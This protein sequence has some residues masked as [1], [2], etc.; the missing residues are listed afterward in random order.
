MCKLEIQL[1]F[2][3]M[4]FTDPMATAALPRNVG[5]LKNQIEYERFRSR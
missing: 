4:F 3:I 1:L 5:F 2:S